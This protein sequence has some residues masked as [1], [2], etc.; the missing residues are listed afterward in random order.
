MPIFQ[1]N[2]FSSFVCHKGLMCLFSFISFS[3]EAANFPS[4]S[5]FQKGE[6]QVILQKICSIKVYACLLIWSRIKFLQELRAV[7]M[8]LLTFLW[9]SFKVLVLVLSLVLCQVPKTT[10][11]VCQENIP[12]SDFWSKYFLSNRSNAGEY[13]C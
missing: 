7:I 10:A 13:A 4:K 12:S 3:S 8:A 1:R 2:V 6:L 9:T 5:S 11:V